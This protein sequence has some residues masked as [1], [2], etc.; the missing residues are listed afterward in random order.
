MLLYNTNVIAS[1]GKVL[2]ANHCANVVYKSN[3][4]VVK[5]CLESLYVSQYL[6]N[7][8]S[9]SYLLVSIVCVLQFYVSTPVLHEP[10]IHLNKETVTP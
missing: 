1:V 5:C 8:T 10:E 6:M 4:F 7:C 9:T 3:L 2:M